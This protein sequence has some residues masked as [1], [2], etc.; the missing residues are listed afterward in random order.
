MKSNARRKGGSVATTVGGIVVEASSRKARRKE[1]RQARKKQHHPTSKIRRHDVDVARASDYGV[2]PGEEMN[3]RDDDD[4]HVA[5]LKSSKRI[6]FS[7]D[8][9]IPPSVENHVVPAGSKSS[10]PSRESSSHSQPAE[11]GGHDSRRNTII[12]AKNRYYENLDDET[13]TA[14]RQD[15]REIEYLESNLGVKSNSNKKKKNGGG[16]LGLS[17]NSSKAKKK[18]R[19]EYASAFSGYGEDFG[20]FLDDLDRL[21]DNVGTKRGAVEA[22]SGGEDDESMNSEY[23]GN[24]IDDSDSD[25]EDTPSE[26]T[27]D[28]DVSLTYRPTIGEDIY[29]NKIDPSHG[30]ATKPSKYVPPHLRKK[31]SD[32]VADGTAPADNHQGVSKRYKSTVA[33]DPETITLI[34]R[35]INNALNRL[36]DQTLESVSKSIASIYSTCPFHDVNDCL[37]KNIQSACVPHHMIMSGLI[38]LYIGAISGVH[39]LGGDGIQIGGC[40]VEWSVTNLIDSLNKGRKFGGNS[41]NVADEEEHEMINKEASNLLLIVCYLYNYGVIHCTLI[42]DLVRDF[43]HNFT[44]IDVEGLLIILSHCGQQLRADDPTA[45]REIVLMVKDRSQT[46]ADKGDTT[47]DENSTDRKTNVADSSRIQYMVDSIIALKNN[48]PRKQDAVIREKSNALKKHISRIKTSAS[49]LL[50]G[51]KSGSCLRVTLQDVLDAEAKGRWWMVGA[52][53]TGNQHHD[54]LWSDPDMPAE[55]I[56][57]AHTSNRKL[58]SFSKK[59]LNENEDSLLAL[60]SSLRMNTDARRSIFCIVMGSTDCDDAFEKIVRGGMLKPKVERDVIRVLVHCCGE[61][62]AYNPFYAFLTAR[63][64]E[65]QAKSRFTLMLTFWDAFKQLDSFS[66]RKVANLAKL[67]AH[68]VGA[69]DKCVTIGVLKRID[70]APTEMT[71]MV[72]IFLSIFMTALFESCDVVSTHKI[73]AH[74]TT[75]SD[76]STALK[77]QH[78]GSDNDDDDDDDTAAKTGKTKKEDLTE[79]RESLSIFL[80]QYMTSS[81]K[82]VVGSKFHSNLLAAI[83]TCGKSSVDS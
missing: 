26:D 12:K 58:S 64:C 61:E 45:L 75:A 28:H 55:K 62:K 73:F 80:L 9:S 6:K 78:V 38:P 7:D 69:N 24:C 72:I 39:W 31:P 68:F 22:S 56:D 2:R 83:S 77:S 44:E 10:P 27:A 52:S 19:R 18:L 41:S 71:E 15:D 49:Q 37:W 11:G 47:R 57:N 46:A 65:Y 60:A 35:Q 67:L 20:D 32:Q 25:T 29:G 63:C 42:Y 66:A 70:F 1:Q 82:N 21:D 59:G 51:K 3:P 8:M 33:A 76:S 30:Q 17:S 74:G 13:L 23:D 54:K 81:P 50:V 43:I 36:S 16:S 40:L 34:Q 48:K 4:D 5:D 79:L 53:W 14:L